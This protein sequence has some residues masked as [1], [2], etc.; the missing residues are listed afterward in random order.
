[1]IIHR[2]RSLHILIHDEYRS[3]EKLSEKLSTGLRNTRPLVRPQL[4][5]TP[6]L[7]QWVLGGLLQA[8]RRGRKQCPNA[9]PRARGEFPTMYPV[10]GDGRE[11]SQTVHRESGT[12]HLV[13]L[14]LTFGTLGELLCLVAGPDINRT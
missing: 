2:L 12:M 9:L 8:R 3:T 1:M 4:V 10:S 13:R 14:E 7:W 6:V 5:S 11:S